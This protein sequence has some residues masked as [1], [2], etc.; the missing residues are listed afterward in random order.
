M[1]K[2]LL[3]VSVAT[4]GLA[5]GALV[6]SAQSVETPV[7]V[8]LSARPVFPVKVAATPANTRVTA[9]AGAQYRVRSG[10]SGFKYVACDRQR[11]FAG[12]VSELG[13]LSWSKTKGWGKSIRWFGR[14]ELFALT[15]DLPAAPVESA[16]A[17]K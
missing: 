11:S 10:K 5:G 15:G 1:L 16:I 13:C 6:A 9:P 12:G 2:S 17:S 3:L 7:E 4:V 8:S 14:Y